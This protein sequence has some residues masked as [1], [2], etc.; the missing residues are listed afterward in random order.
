MNPADAPAIIV[1][2]GGGPGAATR[3]RV[4]AA[5]LLA[6]ARPDAGVIVSGGHGLGRDESGPT[7]AELMRAALLGYG[8]DAGRVFIE[9]ESRDTIGNA[10]F[11]ALRYLSGLAPRPLVIV[12]SPSHLAR[13]REAFSY[14]LPE[15]PLETHA[16]AR[17]DSED[18]AREERL[19]AETRSFLRGVRP[20]DHAA[21]ARR[22]RERWPGYRSAARLNSFA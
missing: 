13:A 20:G 15:W 2:L 5:A 21:I 7:E 12:T 18:D 17:L 6:S 9:D 1:V 14:V 10:L 4:A 11:T 19:L 16:S 22:L 8:I 3:A